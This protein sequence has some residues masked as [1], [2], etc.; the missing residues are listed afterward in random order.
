MGVMRQSPAESQPLAELLSGLVHDFNEHTGLQS[1]FKQ[2]G[3]PVELSSFAQQ[4]LF[5]TVQESLTNVQKHAIE[6]KN[7]LVTLEYTPEVIRLT[8]IDDGQKPDVVSSEQAG[9]GLKGLRGFTSRRSSCR[10]SFG[11]R[12][13]WNTSS[14]T[15]RSAIA[16][17][18]P[19][20]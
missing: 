17:G 14:A 11:S 18:R 2:N 12:I 1:T 3:Q 15:T 8:V 6:A 9:F 5:R 7:I 10:N 16:S 13:E 19:E 4:T 20:S